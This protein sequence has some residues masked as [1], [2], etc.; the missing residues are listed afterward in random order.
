MAALDAIRQEALDKQDVIFVDHVEEHYL[1]ITYQS[2][3]IFRTAHAYHGPITHVL[4]CDDDSYI[5]VG[6]MLAFLEKHPFKYSYAGTVV[7]SYQPIR[8][9][10]SK[11]FVSREEWKEDSS[12]IKWSNG[13]GYVLTMDLA[14][15]LATGGVARC[16]PGPL[17]KIE[18]VA[19]GVWLTC[20]EKE[21]NITINLARSS[22][23]NLASCASGDLVSH[24]MGPNQMLCMFSRQGECCN[25][26]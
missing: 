21:Q 11:W 16:A 26:T 17:F 13:P 5:H 10:G 15:L 19:V 3:E 9:P 18:D 22:H 8:D 20:L 1:N 24:Y 25:T 6:R 7:M 23:I 4:K 14:R 2:L 12:S